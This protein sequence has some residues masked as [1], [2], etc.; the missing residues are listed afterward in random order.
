MSFEIMMRRFFTGCA[1]K[2]RDKGL[3]TPKDIIRYDDISYGSD[4]KYQILDV[5]RPDSGK[6]ELPVIVSVHGG[7]WIYGTKDV[8]QYYCMS[9]AQRGF[10]VVNFSY[11]LAPEYCFPAGLE[12]TNAVF[13]WIIEH[14]DTYGFDT[15]NIF[16][17][18]DSAGAHMLALYACILSN[19]QYAAKYEFSA[20]ARLRLNAVALNCG[21]YDCHDHGTEEDISM[22]GIMKWLLPGK[23]TMEERD[24]LTPV[25]YITD[26]FPPTFIMSANGDF[27]LEQYPMMLEQLKRHG[28]PH[29]GKVYGT[30]EHK[31]GHVFHIDLRNPEAAVCN[32]D[33]CLFFKRNLY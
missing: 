26:Q 12:D 17:V 31:L 18:G 4:R 2:R 20:P 30:P 21:K 27:L 5:Y 15:Q 7:A 23:G 6:K 14:A 16:A 24:M 19:K 25:Q 29:V 9:L 33:T 1:D 22:T 10:A 32:D 28:I 3:K 8:Y 13:A 11:R